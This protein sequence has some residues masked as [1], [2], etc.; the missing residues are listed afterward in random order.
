M[1][2]ERKRRKGLRSTADFN[3]SMG[4]FQVRRDESSQAPFFLIRDNLAAF[5]PGFRLA[6][7]R[8]A[9]V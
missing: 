4:A 7:Q 3:L 5:L 2:T 1:E 8:L 6:A 9:R